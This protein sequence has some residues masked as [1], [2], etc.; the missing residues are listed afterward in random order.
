LAKFASVQ[1]IKDFVVASIKFLKTFRQW[2]PSWQYHPNDPCFYHGV[3][4]CAN[5]DDMPVIGES[6]ETHPM[7]WNIIG[8]DESGATFTPTPNRVTKF[9][10]EARLRSG[11]EAVEPNH[12]IRKKDLN[13]RV[14]TL[15]LYSEKSLLMSNA[16]QALRRQRGWDLGIPYLS[17]QSEVYHFDTDLLNQH[18]ESTISIVSE[19]EVPRLV[20]KED[21]RGNL[22]LIP[23]IVGIP[24]YEVVSKSLLGNFKITK[25]I[26]AS[27]NCTV[28][29]WARLM[30]T[31]NHILFRFGTAADTVLIFVGL[32]DPEYS[33]AGEG[34]PSYSENL[35]NDIAYS[36]PRTVGSM[37]EHRTQNGVES[38]ILLDATGMDP[39]YDEPGLGDIPYS[40]PSGSDPAY[41]VATEHEAL[42]DINEETW[43][44]FAVINTKTKISVFVT[45]KRFDFQKTSFN[46]RPVTAIINE[47]LDDI[48]IDELHI[49]PVTAL[50]FSA[51]TENTEA[52]LPYAALNH[53]EKWLI[54]EAEDVTKVKTNLFET[55]AFRAAVEAVVQ[56]M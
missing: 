38:A 16:Q 13:L 18:Q 37:L 56:S 7:K 17:P 22:Y 33:A 15:Q 3:G 23:A 51:F 39:E 52:R 6:P 28:E 29:F 12:V 9:D 25:S 1:A 54:L 55:D 2:D 32:A 10:E 53:H 34:D 21:L 19:G 46:D 11:G 26:P 30:D 47:L 5:P 35:E 20:G 43:L 48:N 42:V 44:H 40:I 45:D 24:P 49:D 31:E 8:G 41:S 36:V 50:D 27:E 14:T 4:Y